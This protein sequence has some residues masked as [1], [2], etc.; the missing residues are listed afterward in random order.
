[1]QSLDFK[2]YDRK[3]FSP[4]NIESRIPWIDKE[5]VLSYEDNSIQA[6]LSKSVITSGNDNRV[7]KINEFPDPSRMIIK[8]DIWTPPKPE[9]DYDIANNFITDIDLR[10]R[11]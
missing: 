5:D 4:L 2:N 6:A 11:R 10:R 3:C 1:M 9:E 7:T 8:R